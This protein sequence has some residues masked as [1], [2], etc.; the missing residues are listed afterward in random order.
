MQY[1]VNEI[2]YSIQGEGKDAGRPAVFVRLAGC[3][4]SCH[5]CDTLHITN[6]R[7][8]ADSLFRKITR[9]AKGKTDFVIFTGG[10]PLLQSIAP[11]A[12]DL[13]E[14]GFTLGLETNGTIGMNPRL[15]NLFSSISL[16][17]KVPRAQIS[18]ERCHSLKI[19]YPYIA[20]VTP[21]SFEN[22]PCE[23][24][25]IQPIDTCDN[26]VNKIVLDRVLKELERLQG[27]WHLC[28]QV[29]KLL[30]LK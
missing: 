30:E 7:L 16:S 25:G 5:F 22:F 27:R 1:E 23:Y 8:S 10:E 18:L 17:P 29:H 6:L 4:Q 13:F 21:D 2:F 20:G 28:T 24:R 26:E 11:V 9:I 12:Q 3:N 15:A 19:L 14:Y